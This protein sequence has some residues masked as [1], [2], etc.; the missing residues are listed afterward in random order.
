MVIQILYVTAGT[1]FLMFGVKSFDR[2]EYGE[3]IAEYMF[4]AFFFAAAIAE[5]FL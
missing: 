3:A 2:G 4:S 5:K 1:L